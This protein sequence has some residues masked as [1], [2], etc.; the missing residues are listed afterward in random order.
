MI[1]CE[2]GLG[3]FLKD[4][5]RPRFVVERRSRWCRFLRKSSLDL[6]NSSLATWEASIFVINRFYRSAYSALAFFW[7]RSCS[8]LFCSL[9][10]GEPSWSPWVA[11][12]WGHHLLQIPTGLACFSSRR[13]AQTRMWMGSS[14]SGPTVGAKCSCWLTFGLTGWASSASN[15]PL[16]GALEQC[17][18]ETEGALLVDHTLTIK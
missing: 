12:R 17:S 1:A 14:L 8:C 15:L 16:L 5:F 7:I 3:L 13:K 11:I 10:L 18:I 4:K 6:C 2:N 9:A